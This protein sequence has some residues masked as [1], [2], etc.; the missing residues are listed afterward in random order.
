MP[1]NFKKT[2]FSGVC[3]CHPVRLS[4]ANVQLVEANDWNTLGVYPFST[5]IFL[6]AEENIW[7]IPDIVTA[8]GIMMEAA[9]SHSRHASYSTALGSEYAEEYMSLQFNDSQSISPFDL[10]LPELVKLS[11][12]QWQCL[13]CH[14]IFHRRDRGQAHLNVHTN[15]RP[16]RCDGSCGDLTWL[17]PFDLVATSTGADLHDSERSYFS[18]ES[19]QSH[20]E[21]VM[22]TCD[23][24]CVSPSLI[25]VASDPIL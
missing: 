2:P 23:T 5:K 3:T 12:G 7:N 4:E 19:L 17:A 14:K 24:W 8:A 22:V 15:T 18:Q 9:P 6:S 21:H 20:T 11:T 16:Y 25:L 1:W 13:Q 10:P